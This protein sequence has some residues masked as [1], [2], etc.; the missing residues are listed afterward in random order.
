MSYPAS[1]EI[2]SKALDQIDGLM[3][4]IKSM[5]QTLRSASAAGPIPSSDVT[6]Y[7]GRVAGFRD[8]IAEIAGLPGLPAYAQAQKNLPGLD[9]VAEF[10]ATL[11][12]IDATRAWIITNFP[13]D[14]QGNL[15][16]VK[17]DAN[18]R[19]TTNTFASAPL[20]TFRAEL[21]ALISTIA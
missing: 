15:L 6:D 18:G 12:Q 4:I 14:A 10:Q 19:L 7:M 17:F 3:L 13:K 21:D 9:V 16:M 1:T 5:S 2:L 11:A 8:R 20:A